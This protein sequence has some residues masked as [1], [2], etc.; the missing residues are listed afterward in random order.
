MGDGWPYETWLSELAAHPEMNGAQLG[1]VIADSFVESCANFSINMQWLNFEAVATFSVIDVERAHG[2]YEAYAQLCAATLA[3]TATDPLRLVAWGR[4]AEK[5]IRYAGSAYKYFNT[6]D[7]GS[8]MQNLSGD[9]PAETTA[10]LDA[11]DAAVL[12]HR[13]TSYTQG[14][15]GLSIYFPT[16]VDS[17]YG[18]LYY[19]EYMDTVCTDPDIKA[20]YYYKIAGCLNEELQ[21]YADE[22]GYGVF[23]T[24]DTTPLDLLAAQE[25][26][27]YEDNSIELPVDDDAAALMQ[28][29][30]LS[31]ARFDARSN[32]LCFYGDDAYAYLDED[33]TIR[34][35]FDGCWV[36]LDGHVLPLEIID[37]TDDFIRYRC[38][39]RYQ[40]RENAYLIIAYDYSGD[41]L[42]ILGVSAMDE[43]ADT[44]G[45]NL[46]PVEI[47]SSIA[48]EYRMES[49]D[50]ERI[51]REYGDSFVFRADSKVERAP[52]MNGEYYL[53]LDITDTRGD[54]YYPALVT[55][56]IK[57]GAVI[58]MWIS[59]ELGA[60]ASAE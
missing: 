49:L 20:L 6:I 19:L 60:M 45:R 21:E 8:L 12:Y 22:A 53:I 46:A 29:V 4:A 24:L 40:D 33:M 2:V 34:T 23:G 14:S 36:M 11:L 52:L 27:V 30:T 13:E 28:D 44:F 55:F 54:S 48:I 17:L 35:S 38:P 56:R 37:H 10:V 18:L 41:A 3:D 32:E 9:Y 25:P 15:E 50:D 58:D 39:V 59:E 51:R 26:I 57:G 43:E 1:R 16:N 47:G 31:V 42:S 5:S 7:L